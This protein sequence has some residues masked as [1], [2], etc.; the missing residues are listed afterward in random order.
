MSVV[1]SGPGFAGGL[2][3][4][5]A[6]RRPGIVTLTD[7]TPT[8]AGWLGRAVPAGTVGA[9]ITR[10]DRG[11][12]DATVTGLLARDTAEQVWIATHGWFLIGYGVAV[13]LAF[14]ATRRPLLGRGT[15]APRA[16][17]PVLAR[18]GDGGRRR[19]PRLVPRQQLPMVGAR[20]TRPGGCTG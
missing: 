14:A 6:T 16:P 2:L 19:A 13:V 9:R 15:Q 12:L 8:V 11:D 5:A 17:R 1:V 20:R 7:L 18:R 3:D 10:S 4:S